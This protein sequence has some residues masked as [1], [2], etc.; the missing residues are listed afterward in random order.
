MGTTARLAFYDWEANALTPSGKPV[1][2]LL[3]TQDPNAV[4][5][6]QGLGS[7]P[8]GSPGAG[9]M[10]LYQAVSLAAKQTTWVSSRTHA[11]GPSTSCFGAPGSAACAQAAR[12]HG[13]T[14][15]SAST[16]TWPGPRTTSRIS[17]R[18]CRPGVSAS[19]GQV[20]IVPQGWVVLQAVTPEYG[21]SIPWG[22]PNA[23]FFVLRDNV[24]LFGND[25]TNP[26]AV[27]RSGRHLPTSS[28]G[29]AAPGPAQFQNV[30][31][32]IAHRGDLAAD[33]A[34]RSSSTS[35]SPSTPSWSPSRSS[36]SP[37]TPTGSRA[38]TAPTSRAGSPSTPPSSSPRSCGWGR[39][40]ST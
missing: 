29:S 20:L 12:D 40:R 31:A 25:I 21:Q 9:S 33:S 38:T 24:A 1:A 30:T 8:P 3:Q 19:E 23:Q 22:S 17:P 35:R 5:I 14:P 26:Q 6:S 32:R 11:R 37:R 10:P 18:V 2:S 15:W 28:S 34:R 36:T 4:Q 16:A 39:C 7:A 27:D 13:T